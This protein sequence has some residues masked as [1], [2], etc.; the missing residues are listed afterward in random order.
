MPSVA[1]LGDKSTG[2][3][4]FPPTPIVQDCSDNVF[5]NGI[6]CATVGAKHVTHSCGRVVH[7]TS[8]RNITDGSSSVY[9]NGKAVARIG[10]TIACGDAV[11]QGSGNVF[12]G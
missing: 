11:G 10:D 3:G 6:S 9:C 7:P 2:H 12:A 1:R 5:I 4:C 8:S